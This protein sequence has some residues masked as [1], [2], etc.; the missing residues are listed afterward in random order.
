MISRSQWPQQGHGWDKDRMNMKGAS[1][2]EKPL[3]CRATLQSCAGSFSYPSASGASQLRP[4]RV[5]DAYLNLSILWRRGS[6]FID[7][8]KGASVRLHMCFRMGGLWQLLL[9]LNDS[10]NLNTE[11]DLCSM[12]RASCMLNTARVWRARFPKAFSESR[13]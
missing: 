8:S 13:L 7:P 5:Q 12:P 3:H 2:S 6:R 11:S 10:E 4:S 9:M 1:K